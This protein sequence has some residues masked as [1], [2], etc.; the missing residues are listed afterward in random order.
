M[1]VN[2]PFIHYTLAIAGLK[3]ISL[4]MLPI[5][6]RFLSPESYGTLNFLVSI[7]AMLS[8]FLGFGMAE[9]LFQFTAKIPCS[10]QESLIARGI[11]FTFF[12]SGVFWLIAV[13]AADVWLSILSITI[14][15]HHFIVLMTNL[16]L[17]TVQAIYLTRYRILQQS[18]PYMLVALCQGAAQAVLTYL[19]LSFNFGIF[20]VLLSGCITIFV[21]TSSLVVLHS[22][23]LLIK[24][25]LPSREHLRYGPYIALSALFLY[26]LGGA[27]NWFIVATLGETQLAYY[28]IATQFSL[29]LSLEFEPFRL[30]WFPLRFKRFYAN[31]ELAA[32]GAVM[33]CFIITLLAL[34]MMV[35]AP[36]II[37]WLRPSNYHA[38]SEYIAILCVILVIKTYAELLNLGCYLDQNTACVPLINGVCTDSPCEYCIY[39][40][41]FG[42]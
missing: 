25:P 23:L 24:A 12:V 26:G 22:Q 41:Y 9:M 37:Q 30:W 29:A 32:R 8:I 13:L 34:C 33:G 2:T 11:K 6:T 39:Y 18:K 40:F 4:L 14:E 16:A 42:N 10:Q 21:V 35:F 3:G 31:P 19:L 38:S 27:E 7:G 20:G 28:F 15:K 17:S 5:V 36:F 1:K